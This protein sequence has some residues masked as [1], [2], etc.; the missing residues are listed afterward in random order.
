MHMNSVK[1][2]HRLTFGSADFVSA[3]GILQKKVGKKRPPAEGG[4]KGRPVGEE[5]GRGHSGSGC[6]WRHEGRHRLRT[7][8]AEV[9]C[10]VAANSAQFCPSGEIKSGYAVDS[11]CIAMERLPGSRPD[12]KERGLP[13][14]AFWT[15]SPQASFI[16]QAAYVPPYASDTPPA[17]PARHPAIRCLRRPASSPVASGAGSVGHGYNA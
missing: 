7:L 3:P 2:Q 9:V 5:T 15:A 14:M 1:T 10:A 16:A 6:H 11:H 8:G 13:A 12:C 17:T 4:Q